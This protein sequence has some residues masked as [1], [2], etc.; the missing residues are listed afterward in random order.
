MNVQ[1][2]E[3]LAA[4]A[5]AK[6]EAWPRYFPTAEE[7]KAVDA[8]LVAQARQRLEQQAAA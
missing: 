5:K 7:L 4:E 2:A 8:L 1:T 6:R 3:R